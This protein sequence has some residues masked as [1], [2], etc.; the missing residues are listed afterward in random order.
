MTLQAMQIGVRDVS[1]HKL[2][3]IGKWCVILLNKQGKMA[4]FINYQGKLDRPATILAFPP[5][6]MILYES[7]A[8]A[9]EGIKNYEAWLET[10]RAKPIEDRELRGG[11]R[12]CWALRSRIQELKEQLKGNQ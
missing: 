7:E 2:D 10:E 8:D 4:G 9:K 11:C 1:D 3:A 12:M 6:S 5:S